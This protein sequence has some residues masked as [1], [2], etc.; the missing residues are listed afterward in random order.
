MV[1]VAIH[2]ASSV[3]THTGVLYRLWDNGPLFLLHLEMDRQLTNELFEGG[4]AWVVPELLPEEE[5]DIAATCRIL[6][7]KLPAIS[8]SFRYGF[9][10]DPDAY[11]DKVSGYPV[12][13][14]APHGLTCSTFV[15]AIF[16]SSNVRL[17]DMTDWKHRPE[18]EQWYRRLVAYMRSNGVE[19]AHLRL[20]QGDVDALRVRPHEVAGACLE[21]DLPANFAQCQA[22]GQRIWNDLETRSS[23]Q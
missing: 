13:I 3:H 23:Y 1:A 2:R 20:I 12:S 17:V 5:N 10:Y 19:E 9:P 15:L 4:Y 6:W 21:K 8:N 22:N 16:R 7:K 14:I 11:I 18:D